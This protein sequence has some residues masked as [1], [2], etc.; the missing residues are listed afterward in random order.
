MTSKVSTLTNC[1]K[2]T[3]EIFRL[4]LQDC[5]R[6]FGLLE[7]IAVLSVAEIAYGE[8]KGSVFGISRL[9]SHLH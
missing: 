4:Y 1:A 9:I 6:H 8:L 5:R 3:F 2:L 7:S